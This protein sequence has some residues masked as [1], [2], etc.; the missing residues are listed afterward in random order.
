MTAVL[1]GLSKL[2]AIGLMAADGRRL[3]V[4]VYMSCFENRQAMEFGIENLTDRRVGIPDSFAP[5]NYKGNGM[6]LRLVFKGSRDSLLA[7]DAVKESNRKRPAQAKIWLGARS[8]VTHYVKLSEMF[9][10][11]DE[12]LAGRAADLIW[13]YSYPPGF[14]VPSDVIDLGGWSVDSARVKKLCK[15]N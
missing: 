6:S 4:S 11:I 3:S 15:E 10:D 2:V 12:A 9:G 7:G 5:W 14:G 13:E 8:K 1:V